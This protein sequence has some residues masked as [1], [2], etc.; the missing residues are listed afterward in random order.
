MDRQ[1]KIL[2]I[3]DDVE[4]VEVMKLTLESK[5]YEVIYA[6]DGNEGLIKA[7][8]I[9]PDLIILDVMMKSEFEGFN[10]SYDLR[11]DPKLKY[12]PILMATAITEKTGFSF[13]PDTDGEFLPVD[14]Y[15]EKPVQQNDL[16]MRI[17]RLLNLRKEEIN[18]KGRKRII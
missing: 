16:I 5:N 8:E 11:K 14:D 2:I 7:K 13:S 10:V 15:V 6:Y 17:E 3:E 18:V 12:I 1:V 9:K 4:L